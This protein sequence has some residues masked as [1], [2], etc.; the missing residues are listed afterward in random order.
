MKNRK[1]IK[2]EKEYS[3]EINDKISVNDNLSVIKESEKELNFYYVIKS[4]YKNYKKGDIICNK[5]DIEQFTGHDLSKVI[6]VKNK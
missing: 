1:K 3:S 4:D 2:Y 6:I 5:N